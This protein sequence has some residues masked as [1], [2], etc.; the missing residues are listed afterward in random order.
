MV[1]MILPICWLILAKRLL[2]NGSITSSSS[3]RPKK[4]PRAPPPRPI[5]IVSGKNSLSCSQGWK[6]P[7]F[8]KKTQPNGFFLVVF[9]FLGGVWV[10]WFFIYLPRR[11]FLGFFQFQEYFKVHPDFKSVLR[12]HD[13]LGWIRIRGSMPLTNGSGSGSWV[14][15]L[16]PDPAIFVIDLQDA[17]KN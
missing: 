4:E 8:K 14:R 16:D 11:E 10:F 3:F 9:F 15:I 17:S 1:W 5:D 7:G 6:K 13:I 2:R 12:I